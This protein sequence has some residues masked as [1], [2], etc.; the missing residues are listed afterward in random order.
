MLKGL[1]EGT[2]SAHH[3]LC[4][5]AR[6]TGLVRPAQDKKRIMNW[7]LESQA[8]HRRPQFPQEQSLNGDPWAGI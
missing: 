6:V 4:R 5:K 8:G 3:R 7:G 1:E 2:Q